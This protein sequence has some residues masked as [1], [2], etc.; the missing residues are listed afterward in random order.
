MNPYPLSPDE[1]KPHVAKAISALGTFQATAI[2]W[3]S[4]CVF[5]NPQVGSWAIKCRILEA[6]EQVA[7][8]ETAT[9]GLPKWLSVGRKG[10]D[11]LT[12]LGRV[13]PREA[14]D[15]LINFVF[16][17]HSRMYRRTQVGALLTNP[18]TKKIYGG[19]II[20][21]DEFCC[22]EAK[23]LRSI[24]FAIDQIPDLPILSCSQPICKCGWRPLLNSQ[25]KKS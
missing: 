6:G 22:S 16:F 2:D 23:A 25:I 21:V 24:I 5:D 10:W 15:D 3:L 12:D 17:R 20:Y 8:T 11:A 7:K 19:I 18:D 9:F 1:A 4:E 14:I 13:N